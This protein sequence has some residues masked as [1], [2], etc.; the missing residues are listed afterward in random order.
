M[1]Y[2]LQNKDVVSKDAPIKDYP[3]EMAHPSYNKRS[4]PNEM[5]PPPKNNTTPK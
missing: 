1:Y 2:A 5:D 4:P 3:P